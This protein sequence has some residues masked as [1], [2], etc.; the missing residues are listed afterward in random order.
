MHGIYVLVAQ[1]AVAQGN[2]QA[3]FVGQQTTETVQKRVESCT[4]CFVV[5]NCKVYPNRRSAKRQV[6]LLSTLRSGR[7][8]PE[9]KGY[10]VVVGR[11]VTLELFPY[12][13]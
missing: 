1:E 13:G 7:L 12:D 11:T 2:K 10:I 8:G 3:A 4:A 6:R 5:D 9:L